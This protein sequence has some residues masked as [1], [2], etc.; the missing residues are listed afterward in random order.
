MTQTPAPPAD[1][2]LR[3]YIR[4][5][6]RSLTRSPADLVA[7]AVDDKIPHAPGDPWRIYVSAKTDPQQVER[8]LQATAPAAQLQH[9]AICPLPADYDQIEPHGLLYVPGAYVV[10][11]GR[12]NELYGWD[13]YF[14][15]LGL[16]RDQEEDLAFSLVNQ[17]LYEIEHYGTILNANRT[18]YL[19]RSQPPL[20]AR[21]VWQ[22]FARSPDRTWLRRA[23]PLL[24]QLYADW[25]T[26]PHR[27]P[28]TGLSRYFSSNPRPAPEVLY[29]ERD[30]TGRTHY[31][32]V[33][34]YY[35]T[36]TVPDYDLTLY[37]DRER[38]RLTDL[39]YQG[40]RAMRESGF[41]PTQRFGPFS[42]DIIHYVP[43][44]LNALLYQME[45]DLAQICEQVQDS[46]RQAHW[47][48]QAEQRRDR[49]NAYLWDEPSGL[50]LDY[51]LRQQRRRS[52]EFATTFYPLWAGLASD[53][54]ARRVVEHLPQFEAPG[55]LRTSTVVSGSQWDAPFGWAPLQL[56]AVE[57]LR[58][59]GYV[60]DGDRL[61]RKFIQLVTQDFHRCGSVLEKYDVESCT[62]DVSDA[63]HYGYDTNEIG[64][65]WT[66]GVVLELLHSLSIQ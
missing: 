33:R 21:M 19:N 51:N 32:R 59:Y 35:R 47:Q 58:R 23:L 65:G 62:G 8:H 31:D 10:P 52:Y 39:F 30:A 15:F 13:S 16:L 57:G 41:D 37:Y 9:I 49:I 3:A 26:P 38:D 64:F 63:I 50:Y 14:I 34:D 56:F 22:W 17:L 46:G 1:A 25:D 45:V 6:W 42:V 40:D 27:D 48:H 20:I 7:A 28:K 60:E 29:S 53:D 66:N 61:A 2:S 43:V 54:Q 4:Q 44:C 18:Y 36:H 55:G 5:T 12:F 24:E 11:G